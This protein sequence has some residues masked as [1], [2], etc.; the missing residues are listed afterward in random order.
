MP[1]LVPTLL[2]ALASAS[3]ADAAPDPRAFHGTFADGDGDVHDGRA[4]LDG[5]GRDDCWSTRWD[6]G[7]GFG[8]TSVEVRSGCGERVAGA[9]SFG[10]FGEFLGVMTFD[11]TALTTAMQAGLM[12]GLYGADARR[13]ASA[14]AACPAPDGSFA[15]LLDEA[16]TRGSADPMHRYHPVWQTG[17]P[18]LPPAQVLA[19]EGPGSVDL[20][21][22]LDAGEPDRATFAMRAL[23][24]RWL[25]RPWGFVAYAAHNHGDRFARA[26][27]CA[28]W[29]VWTTAHGVAVVDRAKDRWSWVYL[30]TGGDKLRHPSIESVACDGATVS[31][32]RRGEAGPEHVTAWPDEGRWAVR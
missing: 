2:I 4:D 22:T 28:R 12:R 14:S 24:A 26:A 6:G 17:A 21:M 1:K 15:W 31:I 20:A 30:S 11:P 5:D 13:C 7:S 3:S 18:T 8:G 10:S 27:G 25:H 16:A 23:V 29:D 9:H 19:L 32:V